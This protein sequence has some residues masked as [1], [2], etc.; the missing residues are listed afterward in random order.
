[1]QD[2]RGT[3]LT[4]AELDQRTLPIRLRDAAARLFLPYL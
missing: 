2:S 3:P 1:M 4:Q